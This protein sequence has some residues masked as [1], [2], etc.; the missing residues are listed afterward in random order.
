M[1]SAR[2]SSRC[3][4]C[5]DGSSCA[6]R[7]GARW[8]A[9][10]STRSGT[11]SSAM[12][13]TGRS[14]GPRAPGSIAPP[15]AGWRQRPGERVEDLADV[16]AHHYQEALELARAAGDDAG[17]RRAPPGGAAD[18]RARRRPR[19]VARPA[20][21]GELLPPGARPLRDRTTPAAGAAP[22]EG[23]ADR[24]RAL[25]GAGRGGR[26][27]AR[28]TCSI[29]SGDELGAAEALLDLSRFA[30][31]QRQRRRSA[32]AHGASAASCSSAIRPA[33]CSRSTSRVRPGTT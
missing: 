28:P 9:R 12:S 10:A 1:T 11:S 26:R 27:R 33:V 30:S 3:T 13:P 6:R 18:A 8:R 16:L 22:S 14:R 4:S 23:G 7:G 24:S 25:G 20:E 5:P 15:R 2:S 32:R 29:D 21:G 17:R 19:S 31:L